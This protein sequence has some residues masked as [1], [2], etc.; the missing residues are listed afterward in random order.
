ARA[1]DGLDRAATR[2]EGAA[3]SVDAAQLAITVNQLRAQIAKVP[4][5][6]SLVLTGVV[7]SFA[8]AILFVLLLKFFPGLLK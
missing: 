8:T 2:V 1:Q 3:R 4:R 6:G 5:L 7:T